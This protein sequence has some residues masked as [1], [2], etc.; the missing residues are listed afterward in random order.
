MPLQ[1]TGERA[2]DRESRHHDTEWPIAARIGDR[3]GR[4][5]IEHIT[6]IGRLEPEPLRGLALERPANQRPTGEVLTEGVAIGG[7]GLEYAHRIGDEY[8]AGAGL[9][10]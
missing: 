3:H 8:P 4:G 9:G 5:L 2:I 7:P 6:G 10:A 1:V